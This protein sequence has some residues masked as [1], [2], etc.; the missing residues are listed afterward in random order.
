MGWLEFNSLTLN[1]FYISQRCKNWV[2]NEFEKRVLRDI[3]WE[4]WF[5]V[6]IYFVYVQHGLILGSMDE[7]MIYIYIK[8]RWEII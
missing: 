2:R 3:I 6:F 8:M 5:Y 4:T 7:W 1:G